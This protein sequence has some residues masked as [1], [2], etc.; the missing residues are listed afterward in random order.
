MDD[1]D[2]IT[3]IEDKNVI[4]FCPPQ[5]PPILE[6]RGGFANFCPPRPPR[7]NAGAPGVKCRR[8]PP[9]PPL[10]YRFKPTCRIGGSIF[11]NRPPRSFYIGGFFDILA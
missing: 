11:Q 5:N 6:D 9:G 3:K 2:D 1:N 7:S 10:S 8:D 4:N